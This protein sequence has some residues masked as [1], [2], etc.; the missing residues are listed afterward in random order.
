MDRSISLPLGFAATLLLQ[1]NM[2]HAQDPYPIQITIAVLPPYSASMQYYFTDAANMAFFI[3]NNT[4]EE[5]Y[6]Y[7]AGSIATVDG[8]ISAVVDGSMPW[9]AQALVIPPNVVSM[10]FRGGTLEPI[11]QA[12]GSNPASLDGISEE[13]LRLGIL[14]EG[15]YRICL[16][17]F[18]YSN[19]GLELSREGACS[20]II[21]IREGEPPEPLN[22]TCGAD[23]NGEMLTPQTP[24]LIN[25]MWVLPGGPPPGALVSY[26]FRLVRI[27][28]PSNAQAAL[29][30]STDV[31]HEQEVMTT[32]LNYTQMMPALEEGRM[33]AW[34]V[35]AIPFPQDAVVFRNNGYMRP[36]TFTYAEHADSEFSLTYPAQHDTLPWDLLPIM[37][38]FEP[39]AGP[40]DMP[41]TGRFY[42]RLVTTENSAT[43]NTIHRQGENDDIRWEQGYFRAQ[44]ELL[45]RPADFTEEQ[46]RHINIY[47]NTPAIQDRFKRGRR[48]VLEGDIRTKDTDNSDVRY[49]DVSG[50]FVSGMGKP[51]PL[52]PEHNA[53]LPKNGG[54][55]TTT[56]FSPVVLRFQTAETPFAL[57]PPFPIRILYGSNAPTTTQGTAHERWLLEVSRSPT[58]SNPILSSSVELGPT[59][60]VDPAC[61][62]ECMRSTF[63]YVDSV[64]FTPSDTGT[65]Y[66]RVAWML[67][68]T[69][70]M[71]ETYHDGPV[72]QFRITA[73]D[74]VPPPAEQEEERPR[75]CV[76]I[77]RAEPTPI[78]Q[79]I[80][81]MDVGVNDTVSVGLFNMLISSITW[82]GGSANG[83]GFIPVP[84]MN[85][86]MK[87]SFTNAQIN[88]HK[89]LYTGEVL[90]QYDNEAIVPAAWRT[91]AGLAAGFSPGA[92]QAIDDYLNATGR[93]T[94]QMTGNIPM[95][96]PIGIATDVPG[97]RFTVGIVGMQFT[98]SVAKLN[99]M[100]SVPVPELG[101][102]YGLGVS[103]QVFQPDGV[104][105]PDQ[106]ALLYLVDDVRVGVGGDTLVVRST[107]FEPGN[108]INVVDSGTFAAWDCRGFRALQ[109]DAE[110]RFSRDHLREDRTD[111]TSGPD[112]IIASLK[113][114]TGRGG[115]MG[116]VDFN[117]PFHVDGA[118]GWGI[119]VQEAWLDLASYTNPPDMSLSPEVAQRVGLMDA[120]G[121]AD[122]TWRG[123]YLKRAMLRLPDGVK[124]FGNTERVTALIDDMVVH[125]G[126]L[127][128]SFKLASLIGVNEGDLAGWAIS[129][130]TLQM[131]IIANSFS[132]A[133]MKGRMRTAVS[134]T[135]LDYTALWRQNPITSD[136][137]IEFLIEPQE[138]VLIPVP[139][140]SANLLLEETST[141]VG[142]LG[143]EQTGNYAKATLNGSLTLASPPSAAV[144]MNIS[145]V[146]F[147]NLWFSTQ[148][149]Y[150][151]IDST[152]LF[153][154]ASPQKYMGGEPL[155]DAGAP[156]TSGGSTGGFP[157]SITRVTGER[158]T[159][160]GK[161]AA[162]LAYDINLNLTGTSN[163]FVA[164]TRVA[165]LGVLNTTEIHQWGDH[166]MR[167]DS[168]G[169]DGEIGSVKVNGGLKWYR[170][171]PTYGNGIKGS[172]RA[173]FMNRKVQ[174]EAAAQF[175][176]VNGYKYWYV[177]AM[178]AKKPGWNWPSPITIYGFGGAA[179]YHMKKH[180]A[181]PQ[182][183]MLTVDQLLADVDPSMEPGYTY[184]GLAFTPD[185]GV[186]FGLEAT[187]VF[188]DPGTTSTYNGNVSLGAQFNN[189]TGGLLELYLDG[190]LYV[191]KEVNSVGHV[192]IY[193]NGRISYDFPNDVFAAGFE[194]FVN[195]GPGKVYGLGPQN[196][197]GRLDLFVNSDSWHLHVGNPDDRVQLT[198]A[199]LTTGGFYF[200]V[201]DDLPQV[202]MP[203]PEVA[204]LVPAG[205]LVRDDLSD[206]G[207]VAFGANVYFAH[208]DTVLIFYYKLNG[209]FGF[210]ITFRDAG[211]LVCM[212]ETDPGI[213]PFYARGQLYA[214]MGAAVGIILDAGFFSGSYHLFDV[215][216][217]GLFQCGFANPSWLKGFVYGEYSILHGMVRGSINLP[218]QAGDQCEPPNSGLLDGLNPIGDL[219]PEDFSG[220]PPLCTDAKVCGVDC[221]TMPEAIFNMKVDHA[222]TMHEMRSNGT[223]LPRTFK[224]EVEHFELR[225]K[226]TN[227]LVAGT[228]SMA[229]NKEMA[230]LGP[231]AYLEP[232][233]EF[234]VS[235]KVR[236]QE[237]KNGI[238]EVVK[239]DNVPVIWMKKHSFKTN[240]GIEELRPQD[241]A[242]S[243][244]FL[245]QR[246]LLQDECR[247][248]II[249][250][251][252][253]LA[254]QPVFK[255][256]P[257]RRRE[258]RVVFV[259]VTGG[260]MVERDVELN[261]TDS[262][263]ALSFAIPPLQNSK[264]Y[265]LKVVARD[266]IDASTMG[267]T[268]EGPASSGGFNPQEHMQ[269]LLNTQVQNTGIAVVGGSSTALHGGMVNV[270][271]RS[272]EGYTLRE[273]EK[274]IYEYSFRTS[275]HNTLSAKAAALANSGTNYLAST[276][277]PARETLEPAFIGEGFDTFD[278]NGFNS[279]RNTGPFTIHP[280]VFLYATNTD[281]WMSN[282]A[283][284]VLYDYY[285]IIKDA[286][287]SDMQLARSTIT[288]GGEM[289]GTTIIRD[290]PDTIGMPPYNT[291]RF[292]P[293]TLIWSALS[294]SEAVP[295]IGSGLPGAAGG[296]N[297]MGDGSSGN[298]TIL[299]ITTGAWTRNDYIRLKTITND[300]IVNCGPLIPV[301]D[302]AG[303]PWGGFA[304]P[305]RSKVLAFLNGYRRMYNGSYRTTLRFIPPPSCPWNY[306]E[307]GDELL[308]PGTSG[309]AVYSHPLGAAPPMPGA[310]PL[311]GGG[312]II[313][314]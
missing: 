56:G 191:M 260:A 12:I 153:S 204:N 227:A 268:E 31:V 304:E 273:D 47:T 270:F 197:A 251:K 167:L 91:G 113:T 21:S 180:G 198:I 212:G 284:P 245:R 271:R 299:Q 139:F 27:D 144:A 8:S 26:E 114:R 252:S 96:L 228:I 23:G 253:S 129:V 297:S 61:D 58:M 182:A 143:H 15:N 118:E 218:F 214:H 250:C 257:G 134:S 5:R 102:N 164:T 90:G 138:D 86:P 76:S 63:Y 148:E 306:I 7:L 25:F 174:V 231:N 229:T 116:R 189:T 93:L 303:E 14:P 24:Q 160:D 287:C 188:S 161:P 280:M 226:S 38:R 30:T 307:Q 128:A 246:F 69:S 311:P 54:D 73:N 232:N 108:Y 123:F 240:T 272:L 166:E 136:H 104:G 95:G 261:L 141:V 151:N 224:L 119:A 40:Y 190:D 112:K 169:V 196:R 107:R 16:Q 81:V 223:W 85:C 77:C 172:L 200:M 131:D 205:Y 3:T 159:I 39:H 74:T 150:T 103:D 137:W 22:P 29:E 301:I 290:T 79:R 296:I 97:G 241:V 310:G 242:W 222:F 203:P 295:S 35:R 185:Q 291:V 183:A 13:Q 106:D 72:R 157:I 1:V 308:A 60:L 10:E 17:A 179:W 244:P 42:S 36:C 181:L 140:L 155:D 111:G 67:D 278:A 89:V 19:P 213:G 117:K 127:T 147:E 210:D 173:E 176:S 154:H 152:A 28:S 55:T 312:G 239:R 9:N 234:T 18:D 53:T 275:Q 52:T 41:T 57:R 256:P 286:G 265:T 145:G 305:L 2:T 225:K 43:L 238:W 289:F 126:Q 124:R 236:A 302:G 217:A 70:A 80:P 130:D 243:Y 313:Q 230:T 288:F 208:A 209:Q 20:N 66:W 201:G 170:D 309:E 219:S 283:K 120:N 216:L 184:S 33:Y 100:M 149:P 247:N 195:V 125:N 168:I 215:G 46:A 62:E 193:G 110:W 276:H 277:V 99:A 248:G 282:W 49:G 269:G 142:T 101:F 146:A 68:P 292:H 263:T 109:L 156:P 221:G 293:N 281:N 98:D 122:P 105:C 186:G 11:L 285:A 187:L 65:F 44:Y 264:T 94:T 133:V 254:D 300:V 135:L 199:G 171:S 92:V 87:V 194:M 121:V 34:W 32:I 249:D 115:F 37:A 64:H 88:E 165:T 50:L 279:T 163:I 177:D 298:Q 45:G 207:G 314:N 294:D 4:D 211:E 84:F 262:T 274:L 78:A 206:A 132:Q 192:P 71:G 235:I 266:V 162:G 233:T 158:T 259:P 59:L 255:A 237:L 51:R 83:E 6:I 202:P 175:G 75:E 48:Y 267:I 258:Y 82:T 178:V 220:L